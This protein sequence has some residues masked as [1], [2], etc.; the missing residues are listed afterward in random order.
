MKINKK[1]L[2]PPLKCWDIYSM[3]LIEHAQNFN[4]QAEI[5]IL[6]VYQNK[7]NWSLDIETILN[8]SDYDAIVLTNFKQEIKWVNKGFTIMTGYPANFAKGKKPSFLQGEKSSEISINN[9]RKKLTL[10]T[11]FKQ[12]VV[13]YR[14]NGDLYNCAIEIYPL[15]DADNNI[16]H[17]LALESE[18]LF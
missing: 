13:N 8:K 11:Y 3:F 12:T 18:V 15:K 17:L 2:I 14:K 5:E 16:Q 4:K 6:K 7:F 10:G 1:S 9:I